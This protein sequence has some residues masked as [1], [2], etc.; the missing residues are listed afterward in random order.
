MKKRFGFVLILVGVLGML[1]QASALSPPWWLAYNQLIYSIGLDPRLE[2]DEPV[3]ENGSYTITIR[4][5][6]EDLF[7]PALKLLLRE[8]ILDT[9]IVILDTSG[10][11]IVIPPMTITPEV[12]QYAMEIV[13]ASNQ[14]VH[15]TAVMKLPNVPVNVHLITEMAAIQFYTD[16]LSKI[17]G[18]STYTAENLLS[19]VVKDSIE[20]IPVR[21]STRFYV[22]PIPNW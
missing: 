15:S 5:T 9:D 4:A 18:R 13:F 6:T 2:I 17:Y 3:E 14:Y 20:G 8:E 16:D 10:S 1:T 21:C 12:I 7:G 11:E 22:S 19:M